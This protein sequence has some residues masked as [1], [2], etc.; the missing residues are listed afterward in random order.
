M[1]NEQLIWSRHRS[2]GIPMIRAGYLPDLVGATGPHPFLL[3]TKCGNEFSAHAG[4]YWAADPETVFRCCRRLMRL[5][6]RQTWFREV[7]T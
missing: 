6:V 7:A 5:V 1:I 2:G 4:D 3:C